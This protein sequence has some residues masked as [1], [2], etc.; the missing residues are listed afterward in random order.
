MLPKRPFAETKAIPS[1]KSL[2]DV[3]RV[4]IASSPRVLMYPYFPFFET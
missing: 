3:K 1:E 2:A 4:S